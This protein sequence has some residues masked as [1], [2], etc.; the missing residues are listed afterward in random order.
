MK[1]AL[2]LSFIIFIKISSHVLEGQENG[3]NS[4][5]IRSIQGTWAYSESGADLW[6]K[7]II[8]GHRL[9]A[10]AGNPGSGRYTAESSVRF[11]EVTLVY[12]TRKESSKENESFAQII[13][14]ELTDDRIYL[15]T[16]EGNKFL[17][18]GQ[19]ETRRFIKV[20]E[21]FNPWK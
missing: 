9:K 14:P 2:L 1:R 13:N 17:V 11:R 20:P 6:M 10:Y 8:K 16:I 4:S 5:F 19:N 12:K 18:F 7:V 21:D 15:R 3:D